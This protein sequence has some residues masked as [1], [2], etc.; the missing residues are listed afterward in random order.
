MKRLYYDLHIHSCLSPCGDMDMTPCNIVGMARL[1]GLDVI[2][3]C[4]HNTAENCPAVQAAAEGTHLLF[5]PGCEVCTEEE[6]HV[7]CLFPDVDAALRFS[8]M[9]HEKLPPICN[10]ERAFG[11]Q[12]IF[13]SQDQEIGTEPLLLLT[14]AA[15]SVDELPAVVAQYGGFCVPAHV[16]RDS[17]SILVSLGVIPDSCGFTMAELRDKSR[18]PQLL[19]T[20]PELGDKVIVQNSDAHYLQDIAEPEQFFEV[21]DDLT[22]AGQ[23]IAFLKGLRV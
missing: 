21:P 8:R 16:D 20:N 3:V 13:D 9:L 22:T 15:L 10:D 23:F 2:A 19:T 12:S 17:F 14:G 11:R 7:V 5:I 18:L 4:D 1:N 6:I